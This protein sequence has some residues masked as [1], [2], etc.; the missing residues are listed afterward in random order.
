MFRIGQLDIHM[1]YIGGQM[2]VDMSGGGG[3]GWGGSLDLI[4]V[5]PNLTWYTNKQLAQ[6]TPTFPAIPSILAPLK[7]G[8]GGFKYPPHPNWGLC[9]T[10]SPNTLLESRTVRCPYLSPYVTGSIKRLPRIVTRSSYVWSI[11]TEAWYHQ[12][13]C[14]MQESSS[15]GCKNS[16]VC[17]YD[18]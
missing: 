4:T 14:Y 8:G 18:L 12:L 13:K 9:V 2:G 16:Y 3:G 1:L 17:T 15:H 5:R 10:V 6:H 7:T 11:P